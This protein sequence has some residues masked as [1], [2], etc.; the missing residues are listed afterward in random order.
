M[1]RAI[2]Y[3]V[4]PPSLYAIAAFA[5]PGCQDAYG[6]SRL[7]SAFARCRHPTARP[8]TA[9]RSFASAYH[10]LTLPHTRQLGYGGQVALRA[11]RRR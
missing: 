5:T 10:A 6:V 9:R 4:P 1:M 7:Q 8:S 2:F 11:T 3:R